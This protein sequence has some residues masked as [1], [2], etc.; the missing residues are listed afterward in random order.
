MFF[1]VY[2]I[3]GYYI[4]V[5]ILADRGISLTLLNIFQENNVKVIFNT[6]HLNR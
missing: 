6:L 3:L 4:S 1:V 2:I 5:Y